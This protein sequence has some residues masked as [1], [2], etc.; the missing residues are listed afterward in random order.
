MTLG[1]LLAYAEHAR[2][3]GV[4]LT[5]RVVAAGKAT[6]FSPPD[7]LEIHVAADTLPKAGK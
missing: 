7:R 6:L 4:P 1:D 3:K 5:E 2:D